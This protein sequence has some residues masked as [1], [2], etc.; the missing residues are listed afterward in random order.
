MKSFLTLLSRNLW[1]VPLIWFCACSSDDDVETNRPIIRVAR[2][3]VIYRP[4]APIAPPRATCANTA[5]MG[6][7]LCAKALNVK[8]IKGVS[9][10]CG[11]I[12]NR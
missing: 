2:T 12:S 6:P 4:L 11:P 9:S 5:I 1:I 8:Q 3:P 10:T 7:Y